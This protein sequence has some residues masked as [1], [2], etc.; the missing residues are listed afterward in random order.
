LEDGERRDAEG[1]MTLKT[2]ERCHGN[3]FIRQCLIAIDP[4]VPGEVVTGSVTE[5]LGPEQC[6]ACGGSGVTPAL[7]RGRPQ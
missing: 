7:Q 5:V 4:I 1:G 2:C 3:G 6:P